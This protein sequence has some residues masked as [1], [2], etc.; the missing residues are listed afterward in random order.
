MTD[1]KAAPLIRL[2]GVGKNYGNVIALRDVDME[3]SAGEVTCVLG[4][5]GAG[6]STLIKV[7]AG[8]HRHD[9]G[10]YEVQGEEVFFG[11]P[12]EALDRGIATVY[13]DLAVVPL[14]PVWR[15]F[16]LGSEKRRGFGRLDI[17]FM[18]ETTRTEMAA[19]GIDLRDVDQPIGT[20][21][22][23]ERQCVAIARAVHFGA[24]ALVLDEP[25]A[26]LGV[27][28]AGVVLRYVLQAR[29]RG[30]AVVFITHNPHHAY[31][32]GDRF[33]ILNRGRSIGYHTKDE[34]TREELTGLMAGG[35]ELEELAHELDAASSSSEGPAGQ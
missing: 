1:A 15:N 6:K 8:L 19:M 28:Q 14:M 5:N 11:S 16:F 34:I 35:A 12:R 29:E 13:Q 17:G 27:K 10:T 7:V 21:S 26:A 9:A 20:L 31:P 4:D 3:V 24:K 22:G 25:T 18:R 33:L 2:A 32:V 23:G 30:L